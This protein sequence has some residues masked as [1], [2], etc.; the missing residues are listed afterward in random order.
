MVDEFN[1]NT[2]HLKSHH[3]GTQ[4][5]DRLILSKM[6]AGTSNGPSDAH[7]DLLQYTSLKYAVLSG[8]V[9]HIDTGHQYRRHRSE[10]VVGQVLRTLT[11]KYGLSR[12]EVFITSKQGFVGYDSIDNIKEI[13]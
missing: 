4:S 9:N 13:L 10:H 12:E 8:G 7:E 1:F 5:D 2:V 11:E 3:A 6:V